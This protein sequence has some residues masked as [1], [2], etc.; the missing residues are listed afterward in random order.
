[1]TRGCS[2]K[3]PIRPRLRW[4]RRTPTSPRRFRSSC[5]VRSAPFGM[6]RSPFRTLRP[7]GSPRRAALKSA[8]GILRVSGR[9][10]PGRNSDHPRDGAARK[11][12]SSKLDL[13]LLN[14]RLSSTWS[15]LL[16]ASSRGWSHAGEI[17]VTKLQSR[18][19]PPH[20]SRHSEGHLPEPGPRP[21][22]ADRGRGLVKTLTEA[23]RRPAAAARPQSAAPGKE[24]KR[25]REGSKDRA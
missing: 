23:D 5:L 15:R 4:P 9:A 22:E 1:M 19:R 20:R 18:V 7:H 24:P 8:A 21:P 11:V 16:R 25:C 13:R 2:P 10:G 6:A 12:K 3:V 14:F 17:E